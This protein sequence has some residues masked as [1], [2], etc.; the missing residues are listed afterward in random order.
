VKR[1]LAVVSLVATST[2]AAAAPP[3]PSG[4]HPRMLLDNE[5]RTAWRAY[6]KLSAGP[7]IGAIRLCDEG[8][9]TK[10]HDRALYQG[11]EWSKLLQACLV[12]Y[13]ATDSKE[14]AAGAI[15]FFNALL[16]DLDAVGDARGGDEAVRR[17]R[18][19]SIRNL[20]PYTALAYDWLSGHP[21]MTPELKAKARQRW[22]AWLAWYKEKGYRPTQPASNY[23]AG[24]L[25]AATTIAIAQAGEAGAD[26]AAL[27][28]QVADEMWGQQMVHALSNDGVL[29]GGNWPEGWQYGPLSVAEYA[30][31]ARVMQKAGVPITGVREWL[32]SVMRHHV[33]SLNPSGRVYPGGDNEAETP[34]LAP[35][36]LTLDAI[37]LGDSSPDDKAW[38]LGELLRLGLVD[39]DWFLY[40]ALA[41]VAAKPVA[42][43]RAAWPTWYISANT[44]TLYARTRWD[45]NAIWFAAECHAGIQTDHRHANAGTFALSRGKD[46]LIVDPTPYGS[47]STLTTNAPTVVSAQLPKDYIPSQGLWSEQVG[48][49]F[50]TSRASGVVAARCDYADAYK[51]QHRPTDVPEALRDFVLVPNAGGTDAALLVIDR[52]DTTAADRYMNLRFRT[53]GKLALADATA[54]AKVGATQ[55]AITS[56]QRSGGTPGI[57]GPSHKDCYKAGTVKGQCDAAR[58]PVSDFRVQIP[59]P[60]PAAVHLIS[61]TG[62]TPATAAP[63]SGQGWAGV[64]LGGVRDATVI[65]RTGGGTLSYSAAPGLHVILD[66][67]DTAKL[68]AKKSGASC[69]V[70]VTGADTGAQ[71]PL[72]A[73]LDASCNVTLDPEAA[74][75]SAVGTKPARARPGNRSPRSGCCGAEAA[76]G[77]SGAMI[78]IV[79]ALLLRRRREPVRR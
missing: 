58:F 18:G 64:K 30:L 39:R 53:P 43:P 27:W 28:Q 24:Y 49:D 21:L 47:Q 56:V 3:E 13:A 78:L 8:R 23:Y 16:D 51:F 5:L 45:E 36:V 34:H 33:Y 1:V 6:A 73:T 63:L 54:T 9:T 55:L 2:S 14:H 61:A 11:S 32:T 38:A 67:T 35:H 59:G 17:D 4:P 41:A 48:Y 72:S 29:A 20:G 71:K 75:A 19:Y 25:I 77:Q 68:D 7:V 60:R 46:D 31:G 79:A 15:K 22:K 42:P 57:G 26:G 76:P 62:G 10:E 50:V 70:T 65:W 40:D 74:A 12:A 44:G 37:A 66:A 69:A 52:A